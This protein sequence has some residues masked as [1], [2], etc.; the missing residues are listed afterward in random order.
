MNF[1]GLSIFRPAN[2]RDVEVGPIGFFW[3]NTKGKRP[4]HRLIP[5]NAPVR[6]A[7]RKVNRDQ[8]KGTRI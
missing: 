3:L 2:G 4:S 5:M 6:A 1:G 7:L 8:D